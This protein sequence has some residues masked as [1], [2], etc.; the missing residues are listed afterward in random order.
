MLRFEDRNIRRRPMRNHCSLRGLL[1]GLAVC[2]SAVGL[3]ADN[4]PPE[5]Y[6]AMFNG[7]DLTGWKGLAGSIVAKAKMTPEQLAEAQAKADEQMK[8]HWRVEDGVL[9]YDGKGNSLCS[10]KDYGD[11]EL[12]VDWKLEKHGD[13]GIY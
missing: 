7:K 4:T 2:W 13:S 10:A 9:I 1:F 8:A 5:G 12:L 3:A 11:F 6:T